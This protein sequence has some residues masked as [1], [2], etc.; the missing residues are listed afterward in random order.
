LRFR[1]LLAG[2]GRARYALGMRGVLLLAG[3][4]MSFPLFADVYKWTDESGQLHYSDRPQE[5]A[6]RVELESAQ[7]FPAPAVPL[8]R[9]SEPPAEAE[10]QFSYQS[11]TITRPAPEEVLWNIEGQLDVAIELRPALQDGHS[12]RLFLDGSQVRGMRNRGTRVRLAEVYRGSHTLRA[13][14]VDGND[15]TLIESPTVRF[16]VRQTSILSPTNPNRP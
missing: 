4:L 6:E 14:V 13:A 9:P 15:R 8:A 3:L 12:I 7:T 5:G 1:G 16:T 2:G 10:T 11:L